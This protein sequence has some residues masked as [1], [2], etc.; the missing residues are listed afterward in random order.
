M[1]MEDGDMDTDMD[2][3]SDEELE[4]C[5]EFSLCCQRLKP[6]CRAKVAV[7]PRCHVVSPHCSAITLPK[8]L[9]LVLS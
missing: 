1:A 8:R 2:M 7:L 6:K 9:P 4:R 3:L 5:C